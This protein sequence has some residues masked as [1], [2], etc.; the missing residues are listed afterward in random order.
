MS[1]ISPPG[2]D[3][4]DRHDGQGKP[5]EVNPGWRNFFVAAYNI[6]S[7]MTQS[8]STPNR[9]TTLLWVGRR[10]WDENLGQLVY[11]N[12]STW[13]TAPGDSIPGLS[14]RDGEDGRDSF[15]P[16]PPGINGADGMTGPPG[17]DGEDGRDR[18]IMINP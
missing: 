4:V 7:A 8:G 9:P 17:R 3:T 2:V 12:G 10:Y 16:G 13:V 6:L 18:Y 14:A 11:W 5:I 1:L 15:I